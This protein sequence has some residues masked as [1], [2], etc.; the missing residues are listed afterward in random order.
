MF[1]VRKYSSDMHLQVQRYAGF[2]ARKSTNS[3]VLIVILIVS[4]LGWTLLNTRKPTIKVNLEQSLVDYIALHLDVKLTAG[5]TVPTAREIHI[6]FTN[7]GSEDIPYGRWRIYFYMFGTLTTEQTA[8]FEL[9]WVNGGL[10]YLSP[11]KEQ[12]S[13]IPAGK[14]RYLTLKGYK[15]S[16]RSDQF[17]YWYVASSVYGLSTPRI[18]EC[19]KGEDLSYVGDFVSSVQWKR[20]EFDLYNPY[21]PEDRYFLYKTYDNVHINATD[22]NLKVIP[23]PFSVKSISS[24]TVVIDNTWVVVKPIDSENIVASKL[25]A[26][27]LR[28]KEVSARKMSGENIV[29]QTDKRLSTEQY[30]IRIKADIKEVLIITGSKEGAFYGS[31]TLLSMLET[32]YTIPEVII[33]DKP[34]FNHRGLMLD[35]S[36]NFH[37]KHSLKKLI[38]IMA[39]YK[40]NKL[41]LHLSDDEGWRIEIPSIPELTKY[42]SKRCNFFQEEKCLVP[43]LGS[44][45]FSNSSG[46]GF[47]SVK[48]FREILRYAK[49]RHVQV[50]PEIDIPGHAL[51]AIQAMFFREQ[52]LQIQHSVEKRVSYILSDDVSGIP[53]VQN[54]IGNSIN[55]CFNA[56]YRFI[57]TVLADLQMIYEGIQTLDLVHIGGDEVPR[58]VWEHSAACQAVFHGSFSHSTIK[59]MFLFTIADI[60]HS[61]GLKIAAWEDGVYSDGHGPYNVGDFKQKEVS[62]NTWNNVWESGEGGRAIDFADSGYHVILSMAT[63]LYFDHPY[64]PDPEEPGLYWATRYIDTYKVFGF[65]PLDVFANAEFDSVGNKIN[66][67]SLCEGT[68]R[69]FK[70]PENIIG[71]EACV[72]SEKIRNENQLFS[73]IFPRL[74]ALAERAWHQANWESISAIEERQEAKKR[75]FK[76]FINVVGGKE[77]ARLENALVSYR[78]PPPGVFLSRDNKRAKIHTF[79]S[80]HDILISFGNDST[81]KT[82]DNDITI[83]K[84]VQ[85]IHVRSVSPVLR[86]ESRTVSI[87]LANDAISLYA[88]SSFKYI[89]FV[90]LVCLHIPLQ[91]QQ[92]RS[93]ERKW[94]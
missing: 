92:Q 75:D 14:K 61:R 94:N 13:G 28:L 43:S 31:Q 20:H 19:T 9:V 12:F 11:V 46:S 65:M 29:F 17:P 88:C 59:K 5:D 55:P 57:D 76:H 90:F 77:L 60:A 33:N 4:F 24:K 16:A 64:E 72:W 93:R 70:K 79:F 87:H 6:T 40:M 3:L 34:R 49:T 74:L 48:D 52:D 82:V 44:G 85:D 23:T 50:I 63:H 86:R 2:F 84:E 45:P 54:W 7:T 27:R 36:R 18:L 32:S 83:P 69:Q 10:H 91:Q 47:Y 35:V 8:G 81:W 37:T 15:C 25:L 22:G 58:G 71:I 41:H 73:M 62:V 26:K 1:K 21:S 66:L 42:G 78:I 51:S 53:S 68:C 38:D 80:D 89:A 67:A 56:S 30:A 39:M